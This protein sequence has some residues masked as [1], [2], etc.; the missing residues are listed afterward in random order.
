VSEA[1]KGEVTLK[2]VKSIIKNMK[3]SA[4]H[5]NSSE[6]DKILKNFELLEIISKYNGD[7]HQAL[8]LFSK[9][10]A[11]YFENIS[12]KAPFTIIMEVKLKPR[13]HELSYLITLVNKKSSLTLM[14]KK[15]AHRKDFY[16]LKVNNSANP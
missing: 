14:I 11:I 6:I 7:S 5:R 8:E 3:I 16:E 15:K 10:S 12:V 9:S 2:M 13:L 4:S 1:I